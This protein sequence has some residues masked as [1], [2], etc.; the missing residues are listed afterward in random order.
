MSFF[1]DTV[2]VQRLT[3]RI[4]VDPSYGKKKCG[5]ANIVIPKAHITSGVA[6]SDLIYYVK[7]Y[8]E[9]S[10]TLAYASYCP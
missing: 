8:R 1:E 3:Q 9:E 7:T 4:K 2:T 5:A 6:N 10:N